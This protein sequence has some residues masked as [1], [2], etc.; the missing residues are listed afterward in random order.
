[1]AFKIE[2]DEIE[3]DRNLLKPMPNMTVNLASQA[4]HKRK[5]SRYYEAEVHSSEATIES[6]DL[7]SHRLD[8]SASLNQHL[9]RRST[10]ANAKGVSSRPRSPSPGANDPPGENDHYH[11]YPFQ[12]SLNSYVGDEEQAA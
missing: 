9:E 11:S 3:A 1:M 12:M 8:R 2:A 6:D 4:A 5:R 10:I 7:P